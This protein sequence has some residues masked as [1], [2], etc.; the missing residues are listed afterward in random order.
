[1]DSEN[2]AGREHSSRLLD[3]WEEELVI[4]IRSEEKLV[5]FSDIYLKALGLA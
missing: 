3:F 5:G 2:P 4:T 1:V